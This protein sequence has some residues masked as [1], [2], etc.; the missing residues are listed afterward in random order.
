MFTKM[1]NAKPLKYQFTALSNISTIKLT[2]WL[3]QKS[4]YLDLNLQTL[5]RL[6]EK[7][8][9]IECVHTSKSGHR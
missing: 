6:Y 7:K 8:E 1:V 5:V 9:A 4:L 2:S 3:A